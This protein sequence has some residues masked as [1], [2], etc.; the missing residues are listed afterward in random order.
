ML[1]AA[2]ENIIYAEEAFSQFGEVE[3]FEGR[4]IPDN[5]RRNADIILIRSVTK[6]DADFLENSSVKFIGTAT[7]GTDHVNISELEKRNITF[8]SAKGCNSVAVAEFVLNIIIKHLTLYNIDLNKITL[9]IVGVGNIG[10]LISKYASVLGIKTV[11]NDPPR[12]LKENY[13]SFEDLSTVLKSDIITFH[14]PLNKGGEFNT[15]HL[16]NDSNINSL[17]EDVLLINTSRGPVIDNESLLKFKEKYPESTIALDV[18]ENEPNLNEELLRI[19]EYATP[20]IAGYTFEGKVNGTYFI[21]KELCKFFNCKENWKP[22]IIIP[23]NN[24]ISLDSEYSLLGSLYKVFNII[25]DIN[26]DTI[27]MLKYKEKEISIAEHF[28]VMRKK[29]NLRREFNNY[30]VSSEFSYIFEKLNFKII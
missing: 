12:R 20:H 16:L 26:I 4:K 17:K 8:A 9:G 24:I 28:E 23:S 7:I 3:V 22:K 10:S 2:D 6:I 30:T 11:L 27:E 1:I 29:Y 14:T 18:W 5:L 25:Y 13:N 15:F 21:F 19:I